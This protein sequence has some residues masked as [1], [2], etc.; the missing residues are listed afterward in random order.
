[1]GD[2][3]AKA[4]KAKLNRSLDEILTMLEEM[5]GTLEGDNFQ[6][7]KQKI[8]ARLEEMIAEDEGRLSSVIKTNDGWDF[9]REKVEHILAENGIVRLRPFFAGDEQFY[10]QIREEY[11]IFNKKNI[12]EEKLTASYWDETQQ[13]SAFY[14][15]I[16]RMEYLPSRLQSVSA[17]PTS[18]SRK[19]SG[20]L[21]VPART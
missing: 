21:P 4:Q 17:G 18:H 5:E 15:V 13:S 12:P 7:G 9:S 14:C 11:R 3:Y 16:E 10:F 19:W 2:I 6:I 1:M 8:L 20:F